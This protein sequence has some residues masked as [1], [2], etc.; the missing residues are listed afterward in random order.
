M[1]PTK[2]RYAQRSGDREVLTSART[3]WV[4]TSGSDS[5]NGLTSG[6]P[7]L[8]IQHA[9]D[10]VATLDISGYVITIQVADGTYSESVQLK[11]V[12]GASNNSQLYLIG[13]DTTPS[14][15]V[16]SGYATGI[17]ANNI[18]SIWRVSGFKIS[19][20]SIS[21]ASISSSI[22]FKNIVFHTASFSHLFAAEFGLVRCYGN[23]FISGNSAYHLFSDSMGVVNINQ[24]T[25]TFLNNIT[26]TVFAISQQLSYLT[27]FS[28]TFSLGI[29]SVVGSRY[30]ALLN[31]AIF[32]NGGGANYFPGNSAGSVA[33]GGL[34][35]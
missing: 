11:N 9:V 29:Y 25:I 10:A 14:N 2:I 6:T 13:N 24:F 5:N 17:Q 15:V 22:Y 12:I 3:Y 31:S 27:A 20:S 4:S 33:T 28:C 8:T 34:Y 23:Y 1:P 16:I 30:S 21:I 32:T 35:V 19:A 18:T 7:F 26:F